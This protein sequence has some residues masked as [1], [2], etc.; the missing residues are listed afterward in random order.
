MWSTASAL[1]IVFFFYSKGAYR[2]ALWMISIYTMNHLNT[3]NKIKI[4]LKPDF[5]INN[6][7]RTHNIDQF[8]I[9]TT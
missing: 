5:V 4:Q 7:K 2:V 8:F 9:S 6:L 3:K 1:D